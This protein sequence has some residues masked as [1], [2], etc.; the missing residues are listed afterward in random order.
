MELESDS[1]SDSGSHRESGSASAQQESELASDS[2]LVL[3]SGFHSASESASGFPLA[4][5]LV[6]Y[7]VPQPD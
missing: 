3:G 5:D 1:H 2:A 4:P 7:S 6:M